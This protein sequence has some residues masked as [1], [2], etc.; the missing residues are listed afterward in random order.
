MVRLTW[1]SVQLFSMSVN[2]TRALT[3]AQ[4]GRY[5]HEH[6]CVTVERVSPSILKGS[7]APANRA[8]C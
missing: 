1:D 4:A 8:R 5:K 7:S 6:V 3:R 2:A